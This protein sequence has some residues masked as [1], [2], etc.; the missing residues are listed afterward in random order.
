M[1][2][3][4]TT[5]QQAFILA[6]AKKVAGLEEI[7]DEHQ[8]QLLELGGL[9]SQMQHTMLTMTST[10]GSQQRTISML[11]TD[12]ERNIGDI[13]NLPEQPAPADDELAARRET[14]SSGVTL[15][16]N[17]RSFREVYGDSDVPGL[18]S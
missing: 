14:E 4:L 7:R 11:I 1:S 10:I 2:S 3:E 6:A 18:E 8:R 12:Y 17:Q 9:F 15:A 16:T 5:E 13:A